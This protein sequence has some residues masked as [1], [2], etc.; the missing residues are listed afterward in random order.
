MR[1]A[2]CAL[3]LLLAGCATKPPLPP[4]PDVDT[5]KFLSAVRQPVEDALRQA[6]ARP[7]DPAANGRF[8]MVLHASDQFEAARVCYERASLLDPKNSDWL[9]YL[10][11]ANAADGRNPE[12]ADA[13]RRALR[14][15]PNVLPA[16]L[17]RAQALLD[18]G[19]AQEARTLLE[20][21]LARHPQDA[22]ANFLYGR[23]AS[24]PESMERA[25][26]LF[27]QYGAA[28]FALA[29]HYQRSGRRD[30]AAALVARYAQFKT[31]APP[32]DDALTDAIS[33]LKSGPA[34]YMK[35]A[36]TLEQ[37]GQLAQAAALNEKALQADPKL[38]QAHINLISA[39]AR[40]GQPE[41]AEE[42]YRLAIAQN[43]DASDAYYNF[44]VLCYTANRKR[45]ARQAFEK[46][47]AIDPG[48]AEAHANLGTLL[49]EQ[50]K[51][52]EASAAFRKAI[53][54]RPDNRVARFNLA[55]IYA[56]NAKYDDAIAEFSRLLTPEDDST[57]SYLY[58]MGA[59]YARA[60]K[61]ADAVAT[62]TR[63]KAKAAER[64]QAPVAAA[65]ERDLARLCGAGC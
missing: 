65:I 57:P 31:T 7:D 37:Q 25:L 10:G 60:G 40:T 21:V 29:Q 50:G 34:E 38:T 26:S 16:E 13:F 62:L 55:R 63:A 1:R 20:G 46:T 18:S 58:A 30:E 39:Y 9:Y 51:L 45:E 59:T 43:P 56:N 48:K 24:S 8:G 49:Q 32:V 33:A 4:L 11:L 15:K 2:C 3:A 19:Q 47:I 22:T 52:S 42:H 53:D 5:G 6:R 41:K 44:G 64:G 14:L 54:L 36:A 61:R 23:A 28:M 35:Q 12:A 27:P 17:R